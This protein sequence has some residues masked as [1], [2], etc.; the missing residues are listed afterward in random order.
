M[1][2][3]QAHYELFHI[4]RPQ[5][6]NRPYGD[7]AVYV[8]WS[9]KDSLAKIPN[10][11]TIE[12]TSIVLD[13]SSIPHLLFVDIYKIPSRNQRLLE[14]NLS[15][16]TIPFSNF[17]FAGDFNA[18]HFSWGSRRSH[19]LVLKFAGGEIKFMQ[20]LLHP[21]FS[22]VIITSINYAIICN[23]PF[24]HTIQSVNNLS[25]DHLPVVIRFDVDNYLLNIPEIFSIN[26]DNL[27]HTLILSRRPMRYSLLMM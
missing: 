7:T 26:W 5:E 25:S 8:K 3:Y 19:L 2:L 21:L 4:D 12:A 22:P 14:K 11:N 27:S 13:F 1:W 18:H 20:K 9:V 10:F 17:L 15:N 6:G 24:P 23:S 16:L